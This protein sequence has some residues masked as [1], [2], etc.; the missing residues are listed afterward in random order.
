MIELQQI[1]E[2]VRVEFERFRDDFTRQIECESPLLRSAIGRVLQSNGK[3]IRPLLLLLTAKSC[4]T[5][6]VLTHQFSLIIEMLHTATLIHD[7]VVDDTRRRRGE[8]SLNAVYDNRVSVLTGDYLLA[9]AMQKAALTEQ[10][11]I[12][13]LIAQVCRELSEGELM[14]LDS[15]SNFNLSEEEYFRT[16]RKKTASLL[17]LSAQTG[18]LTA[19]A[20]AETT[21]ICRLFGEYLGYCFQIKDDVFDYYDDASIGKPTGNDIREGKI[22][23]PL[24]YALNTSDTVKTAKYLDIIHNKQFSSANITALTDF[25]KASGGIDYAIKTLNSYKE[26]ATAQILRLPVSKAR[27]SLLFL[28]EYITNRTY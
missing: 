23:L 5:T 28:T 21:E 7:D 22:T 1:A 11:V 20:D 12:I 19:N 15:V 26:K 25:A 3:H 13:R 14:Q 27:E 4:G 24:L 18:A 9:C 2:P 10:S 17:S 6:G 8:P 16:I